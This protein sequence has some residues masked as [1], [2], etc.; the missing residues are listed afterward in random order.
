MSRLAPQK[1]QIQ[2]ITTEQPKS[3]KKK[4]QRQQQHSIKT[5]EKK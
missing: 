4:Q 2:T 3:K 1:Q 5:K